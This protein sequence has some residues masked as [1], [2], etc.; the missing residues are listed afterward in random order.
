MRWG[1]GS[2]E[3]ERGARKAV[4]ASA[5]AEPDE[6]PPTIVRGLALRVRVRLCTRPHVCV[7]SCT[8]PIHISCGVCASGVA[9]PA[10][11]RPA[12]TAMHG[13]KRPRLAASPDTAIVSPLNSLAGWGV[14]AEVRAQYHAA[15]IERLLPWQEACL[16]AA[17]AS[18]K[19]SLLFSA[20]TSAGKSLVAELLVLRVRRPLPL[21]KCG[22]TQLLSGGIK[23]GGGGGEGGVT[24]A[25]MRVHV[26]LTPPPP[27][28]PPLPVG[29]RLRS[30]CWAWASRL[31]PLDLRPLSWCP[32]WC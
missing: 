22:G 29:C 23:G 32:T 6:P 20:T 5:I 26:P 18:D 27:T 10:P 11:Q 3:R 28:P 30:A 13:G 7:C 24:R 2:C 17:E 25:C 12:C 1:E 15:G 31:P 14:P 19:Q 9:A 8:R 4:G 21:D 16:C